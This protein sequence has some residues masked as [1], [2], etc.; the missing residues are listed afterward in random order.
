MNIHIKNINETMC[1]CDAL[2]LP[3]SEGKSNLY[4]SLGPATAKLIKRVFRKDFN[5]K[6]NK[7]L[8]IPA[9]DDLRAERLVLVGLGK[10][11]EISTEKVRQ[12]G[13][14]TAD[15]LRDSGMKKIAL[16]TALLSSLNVSPAEFIEGF[17]LG[18]Y[19]FDKYRDKKDKKP[20][21]TFILLSRGSHNLKADLPWKETIASSVWFVRDLVNT[22]ANDMTPTHLAQKALSLK[23]PRLSVKILE[24][25]DAKKLGMGAYLSVAKGSNEPPKFIVLDYRGAK[26]APIVLV[27]KSITFD[28]GGFSL[29]PPEGMERMKYDMAGGATVLGVLR[30]VSELRLPVRLIGL[31]PATENLIGGSA[32]RP[33]D[34]VRSINGKSIEIINTD[35]EG[36]LVLADALGFAQRYKPKAIIDIATLTGACTLALGSEAIG[37][38]GNDKILMKKLKK[39]GETA[40]ERVWE[41]PLYSEYKDYL[42]S[43]IADIKNYGGRNGSLIASAYFLYE[44]AG[45]VP[46]VHLDIAGTAWLEK[47][48]PYMPKGS[49]G[50]GVRLLLNCIKGL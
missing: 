44:F 1:A 31:L 33:G 16:S 20:I 27:G 17:L 9:P 8:C 26:G 4:D 48:K 40:Y 37:M 41:M 32:T 5:G 38:M 30:A 49:T 43:D 11:N 10:K 15:T 39:A 45:K 12:A 21:E 46:W 2:I 25:R 22:P 3:F 36:R 18:L 28:S 19:V 6:H 50:I 34:V 13:G 23:R 24:K 7:V 47:E 42:K 35:A 14:R 29:K